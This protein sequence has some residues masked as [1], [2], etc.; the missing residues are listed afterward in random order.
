[1]KQIENLYEQYSEKIFK[2]L[3][4]LTGH[5]DEANDLTQETFYQ[6]IL[7]IVRFKGDSQISTWI[8]SIARNT[9]LKHLRKEKKALAFEESYFTDQKCTRLTPEE[10][11]EKKETLAS[12]A[13]VLNKLPEN[14]ATVLILRDKEGL[15]Y[16]E[17]GSIIKISE[18]SVKVTIFRARKKFKEMFSAME[19]GDFIYE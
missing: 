5:V 12:I 1:M 16:K 4:Y 13:M 19:R 17:I 3:Y 18:A 10:I 9:Y 7:S 6:V 14:Y 11:L 8:Y 15:S 2:Y